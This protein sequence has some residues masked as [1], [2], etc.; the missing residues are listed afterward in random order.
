[1]THPLR[2][3][4]I[5]AAGSTVLAAAPAAHAVAVKVSVENLA[6]DD[7]TRLTP[8]FFAIHDGSLDLF[9]VDSPASPQ[10]ERLAEDGNPGPLATLF[11]PGTTGVVFGPGGAF[12][13]GESGEFVL[14]L[15]TGIT[16]AYFSYASMVIPSNDAFIGNS[17]PLA[18]QILDGGILIPQ[19]I[20]VAGSNVYDA[21]T[22]MNNEALGT[23][24]GLDQANPDTGDPENG[25]VVL[26]AGFNA[27]G[28]VLAEISNG[29][30]TQNGY[31]VARITIS[32]VPEPPTLALLAGSLGMG[33]WLRRRRKSASAM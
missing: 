23:V 22:E 16:T 7:G 18:Y 29:D 17:D 2:L 21:G 19:I 27:G 5:L 32:Q 4:A 28:P 33:V 9:D 13:P 11:S 25:L 10:L 6:P 24:A 14:D 20:E 31:G 12:L 30:F 3:A 26:H 1:M 8:L 15:G